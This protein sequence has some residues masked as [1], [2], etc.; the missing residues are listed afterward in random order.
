M[1][2]SIIIVFSVLTAG[3]AFTDGATAVQTRSQ[4]AVEKK[5]EQLERQLRA[6]QRRVFNGED[7]PAVADTSAGSGADQGRLLADLS[8]KLGS[9]ERQM[10]DLTGRLEELEYAG[11]Q[12]REALEALKRELD[13]RLS[14]GPALPATGPSASDTAS[15]T[16][17][18]EPSGA[19]AGGEALAAVTEAAPAAVA[20]PDGDAASQYQYAFDFI[21]QNDLASA[22]EAMTLFLAEHT[23]DALTPNAVFWLGRIHQRE[24]RDGLAAQQFLKLIDGYPAHDKRADALVDLAEILVKLGSEADACDALAEFDGVAASASPRLKSRADRLSQS[25]QCRQ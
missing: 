6:V 21:R 16:T 25:A 23:D 12:N 2:H 15:P 17:G 8:V 18:L 9:L 13:L 14:S 4:A 7:I 20:L 5:I 22:R 19:G 3:L 1:R 24:G 10:R 11:R